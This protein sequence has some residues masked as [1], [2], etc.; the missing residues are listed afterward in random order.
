VVGADGLH[1]ILRTV[2]LNG[3]TKSPAPCGISAFRFLIDTKLLKDDPNLEPILEAKGP[4]AAIVIDA[5]E[6]A[7]ERHIMWYPCRE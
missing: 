4:G 1:S 7:S 3:D 5:Q 6:V 2:V